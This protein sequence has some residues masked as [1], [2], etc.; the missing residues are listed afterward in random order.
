[1]QVQWDVYYGGDAQYAGML[2]MYEAVRAND[3]DG[4][5]IMGGMQQFAADSQSHIYRDSDRDS[6]SRCTQWCGWRCLSRPLSRDFHRIR[7]DLL[8]QCDADGLP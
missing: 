7:S 6:Q 5:V 3:A 2:P 8:Q 1:M 4:I